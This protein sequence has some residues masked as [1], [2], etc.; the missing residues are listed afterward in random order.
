[1]PNTNSKNN[2]LSK[3]EGLKIREKKGSPRESCDVSLIYKS[4]KNY[5]YN[6]EN[7][8]KTRKNKKNLVKEKTNKLKNSK[9]AVYLA[10]I[11][12]AMQNKLAIENRRKK[13]R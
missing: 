3:I 10:R 9:K 13:P 7:A 4:I 11:C 1:M 5:L 2:K 8:T 12:L 6:I